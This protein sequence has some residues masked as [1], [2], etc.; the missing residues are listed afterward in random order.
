MKRH[1]F[2][3]KFI[4]SS[5]RNLNMKGV[6]KCWVN[7][8]YVSINCKVFVQ[9]EGTENYTTCTILRSWNG[10][11]E[12]VG[13]RVDFSPHQ[14]NRFVLRPDCTDRAVSDMSFTIMRRFVDDFDNYLQ[15]PYLYIIIL[16]ESVSIA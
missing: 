3:N 5:V 4:N 2:N 16:I 14:F 12:R 11:S 6:E 13:V 10:E 9:L 1:S 15:L 8:F 7:I